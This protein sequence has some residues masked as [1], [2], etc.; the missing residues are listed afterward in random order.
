MSSGNVKISGKVRGLLCSKCN[1]GIGHF[2]DKVR[3]LENAIK[4]LQGELS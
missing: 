2:K 1:L 4:Y 3:Y